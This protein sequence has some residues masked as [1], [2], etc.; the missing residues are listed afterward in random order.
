[1]N[2]LLVDLTIKTYEQRCTVKVYASWW[3]K[4]GYQH[5][6][7]YLDTCGEKLSVGDKT[8]TAAFS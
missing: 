7:G 1:M 8:G 4:Q 2:L 5:F 3:T 6:F